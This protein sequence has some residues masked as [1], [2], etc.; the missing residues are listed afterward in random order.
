MNEQPL[1]PGVYK[2][3]LAAHPDL[4]GTD[5]YK[6]VEA[7]YLAAG[8]KS[9]EVEALGEFMRD[10]NTSQLERLGGALAYVWYKGRDVA[11]SAG[12]KGAPAAA[13]QIIG[14]RVAGG[15]GARVGAGTGAL[16]GSVAD[17]LRRGKPVTAGE[18]VADV[19]SAVAN[20]RSVWGAAATNVSA[21]VLQQLVDEGAVDP[22]RVAAS[23]GMAVAGQRLAN[24]LDAK[25]VRE[26]KPEDATYAFRYRALQDVK[27]HGISVSPTELERGSEM[28]N[29][30]AGGNATAV[31]AAKRNQNAYQKMVREQAGFEV[32]PKK[33]KMNSL[34]FEPSTRRYGIDMEDGE[35]DLQVEK[36]S[37][38]YREIKEISKAVNEE[39][40]LFAEQKLKNGKYVTSYTSPEGLDAMR[41][42]GAALDKLKVSYRAIRDEY[43]KMDA[44]DPNSFARIQALKDQVKS[45][46]GEI[47]A[48]AVAASTVNESHKN[49]LSRLNEARTNISVLKAIDNATD[50]NGLVSP[51]LLAL[52]RDGGVPLTGNLEKLA[53]FHNAFKA[54][55]RNS[56]EAGPLQFEGATP[57]YTARNVAMGNQTGLLSGGFPFLSEGAREFLLSGPVQN[58]ISVPRSGFP[59]TPG[60]TLAR[61]AG[62][63]ASIPADNQAP[64]EGLDMLEAF[65][66]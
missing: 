29:R 8:G 56:L 37:A 46:E 55:G 18:T 51:R 36:A 30:F 42:A 23:T 45:L 59:A 11:A 50:T 47:D 24:K 20:P 57:A 34:A 63:M 5:D 9:D 44:G 49:L 21:E 10:K 15:F 53:L 14:K 35:I 40:K 64:K 28:F 19:A 54:S 1:S 61:Q 3:W 7:N 27:P 26:I 52:Q 66:R 17:Q 4:K 13:G 31:M 62:M 32:D 6:S 39:T 43:K 58:R 38:P 16:V 48:A 33:L 12:V 2:A 65:R 22:A 60:G 41:G 25:G